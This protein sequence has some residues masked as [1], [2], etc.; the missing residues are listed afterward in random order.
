MIVFKTSRENKIN[1]ICHYEPMIIFRGM[2][3]PLL[4][5]IIRKEVGVRL[6]DRDGFLTLWNLK[7]LKEA[8][9]DELVS[10]YDYLENNKEK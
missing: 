9:N 5:F 2:E 8:H 3:V 4:K 1:L 6:G 7:T 10:L